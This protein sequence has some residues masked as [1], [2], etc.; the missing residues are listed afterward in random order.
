MAFRILAID[1]GGIRGIIPALLLATLEDQTKRPICELFDLIAGAST[2]GILAL[3]LTKP[4]ADGKVERSAQS[5]VS[6]YQE[7]GSIIFPTPFLGGRLDIIYGAKYSSTGIDQTMVKYFG[8]T[9]LKEALKPVLVPS[10][11]LEKQ[12]PIFFKSENARV[13]ADYDFPM[14][15]VA[16]ATSAAPTY[17]Q[18]AKLDTSDPPNY[19]SLIDGGVVAGNPAMCAYAEAVNMGKV[20]ASGVLMVSL[21]TGELQHPIMYDQA[22]HWGQLEWAQPIIDI[23]LQASNATVNYQLQQLLPGAGAQRGYYRF[24]LELTQATE[25]MDNTDAGN[26]RQLVNLTEAFLSRADIKADLDQLCRQL[27][28]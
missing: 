17:F 25:Q 6:L 4:G 3:G 13:R 24:Q 9:R 19:L 18:P 14:R 2:G 20:D 7:E 16:R 5:L 28:A 26:L 21:G 1:G 8:E 23:V 22:C 10:Y 27:T 12:T 11:D 15:E